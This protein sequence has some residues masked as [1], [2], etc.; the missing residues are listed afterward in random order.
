MK[1]LK[2]ANNQDETQNLYFASM[3]NGLR[4]DFQCWRREEKLGVDL[5]L[6]FVSVDRK[7]ATMGN[8]EIRIGIQPKQERETECRYKF[9]QPVDSIVNGM[10]LGPAL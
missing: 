10:K 6:G 9:L 1:P 7:L 8:L 2:P 4:L 3:L 5:K